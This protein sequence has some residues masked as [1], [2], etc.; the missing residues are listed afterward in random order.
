M[1]MQGGRSLRNVTLLPD[2][3]RSIGRER[4]DNQMRL[5]QIEL[6][7]PFAIARDRSRLELS[8]NSVLEAS[9]QEHLGPDRCLSF[10]S[11]I[12]V[13]QQTSC[14]SRCSMPLCPAT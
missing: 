13:S 10:Y 14:L 12:P 1:Q 3:Y 6:Q 11:R 8:S 2:F 4:K 7:N 5:Q 9:L